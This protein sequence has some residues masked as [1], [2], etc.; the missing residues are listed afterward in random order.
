MSKVS[1]VVWDGLFNMNSSLEEMAGD[2]LADDDTI[3]DNGLGSPGYDQ[4]WDHSDSDN[5]GDKN[6]DPLLKNLHSDTSMYP[7]NQPA[8]CSLIL[9][10]FSSGKSNVYSM[11][12]L[13]QGKL[14]GH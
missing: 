9:M 8:L 3:G 14:N 11:V 4:N 1:S 10:F 6:P 13:F 12:P 7:L 2:V 5:D